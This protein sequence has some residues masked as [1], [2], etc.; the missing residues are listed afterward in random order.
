[1]GIDVPEQFGGSG[2]VFMSIL[3]VEEISRVDASLGVMDVRTLLVNNAIMTWGADDL[4]R[5]CLRI[6]KTR[7]LLR[8]FEAGSGGT[9]SRWPQSLRKRTVLSFPAGSCG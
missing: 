9:H 3:A 5:P 1:M 4:K 2:G 7:Q 8:S 6:Y